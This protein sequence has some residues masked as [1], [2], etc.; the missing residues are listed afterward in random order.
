MP[1]KN[2]EFILEI[3]LEI[4]Q[5]TKKA[6]LMLIGSGPLLSKIQEKTSEFGISDKVIFV[7]EHSKCK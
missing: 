6:K 4:L 1:Q 3:F 7:G 5:N 2:H